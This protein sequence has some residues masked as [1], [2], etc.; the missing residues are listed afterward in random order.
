MLKG[1]HEENRVSKQCFPHRI[2]INSCHFSR[3]LASTGGPFNLS[4]TLTFYVLGI[5]QN[6]QKHLILTPFV[7]ALNS[8][9]TQGGED[10][11]TGPAAVHAWA[12]EL[13]CR[14]AGAPLAPARGKPSWGGRGCWVHR[15]AKI[16]AVVAVIS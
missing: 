9:G 3:Y 16:A 7:P 14:L 4:L 12:S 1:V 2:I 15:E 8:C 5:N 13:H 6:L 11:G 10:T